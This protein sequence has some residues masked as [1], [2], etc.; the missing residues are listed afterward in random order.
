MA[1]YTFLQQLRE[2]GMGKISC[3]LGCH[4]FAIKKIVQPAQHFYDNSEKDNI[5]YLKHWNLF[6]LF[7]YLNVNIL[8]KNPNYHKIDSLDFS[9]KA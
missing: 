2:K 7:F 5:G 6:K 9:F 8:T 3:Q 1:G 4:K